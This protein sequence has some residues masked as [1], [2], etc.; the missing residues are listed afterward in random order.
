ML[1]DSALKLMPELEEYPDYLNGSKIQANS[2]G[3]EGHGHSN[4]LPSAIAAH[5][6]DLAVSTLSPRAGRGATRRRRRG[7]T[8]RRRPLW[9]RALFGR[10]PHGRALRVAAL[11]AWKAL[12]PAWGTRGVFYVGYFALCAVAPVE[13]PHGG[14]RAIHSAESVNA[15]LVSDFISTPPRRRVF[16]RFFYAPPSPR[17]LLQ[18]RAAISFLRMLLERRD[19]D[20]LLR[21]VF[22]AAFLLR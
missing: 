4:C 6:S 16:F 9:R 2:P 15:S 1:H 20:L 14:A 10:E 22:A 13:H 18:P 21:T 7:R 3:W 17:F 11:R 8:L 12:C 19:P 5:P